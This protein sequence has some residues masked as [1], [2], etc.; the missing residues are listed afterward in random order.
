MS[1]FYPHWTRT[2]EPR[3]VHAFGIYGQT[4]ILGLRISQN[5]GRLALF[6]YK[7]GNLLRAYAQTTIHGRFLSADRAGLL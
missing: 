4:G 5:E 7:I 2:L 6:K 1:S 3:P